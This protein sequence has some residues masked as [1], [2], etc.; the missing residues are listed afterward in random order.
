[1]V[2]YHVY[3]AASEKLDEGVPNVSHVVSGDSKIGEIESES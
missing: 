2:G 3:E 1:M